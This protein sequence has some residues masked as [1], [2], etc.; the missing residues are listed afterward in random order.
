[1]GGGHR[2]SN[3]I[4]RTYDEAHVTISPYG[5]HMSYTSGSQTSLGRDPLVN[6]VGISGPTE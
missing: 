1:M 3:G 2:N 4:D 6:I 5:L